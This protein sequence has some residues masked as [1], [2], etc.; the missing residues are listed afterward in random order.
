METVGRFAPSPSGRMHLGNLMAALLA[1]LDV[2]SQGG[3]MVLRLEDLDPDRSKQVYIDALRR[4][5]QWLGLDWDEEMPLQSTRN[6]VYDKYGPI[7]FWQP[8][9][10]RYPL[11]D[12]YAVG[13]KVIDLMGKLAK[14]VCIFVIGAFHTIQI[15]GTVCP[16]NISCFV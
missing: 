5:L 13:N 11:L 14:F 10:H 16:R 8:I 6:P 15:F 1:W 9:C 2:R 3:T 7:P 4:D 12:G